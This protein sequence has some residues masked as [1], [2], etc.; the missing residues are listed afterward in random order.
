VLAL[1][2]IGG[3]LQVDL[4]VAPAAQEPAAS[5]PASLMLGTTWGSASPECR[6]PAM[7][8]YAGWPV[9]R[10]DLEATGSTGRRRKRPRRGVTAPGH[11]PAT[12]V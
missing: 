10:T 8:K 3:D 1:E 5:T 6:I 12:R 2:P 11:D 7:R 4:A 9:L